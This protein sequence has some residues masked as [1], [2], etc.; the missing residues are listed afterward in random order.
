MS[1]HQGQGGTEGYVWSTSDTR[2]T[3][4][5]GAMPVGWSSTTRP[6]TPAARVPAAPSSDDGAGDPS[7]STGNLALLLAGAVA[8]PLLALGAWMVLT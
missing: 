5:L 8:L 2:A 3:D 4:R 1:T 6:R 7:P